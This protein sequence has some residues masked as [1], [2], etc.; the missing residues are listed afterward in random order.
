MDA[1]THVA[2]D[3]PAIA[4]MIGHGTDRREVSDLDRDA[5][6]A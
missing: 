4:D 1:I 6:R 3:D 2:A 5:R